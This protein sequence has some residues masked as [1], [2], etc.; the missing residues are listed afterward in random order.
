MKLS[1]LKQHT[2]IIKTGLFPANIITSNQLIHL[3]SKHDLLLDSQKLFDEMPQRNVFTWN[4]IIYAYIHS[5][6]MSQARFL[7]DSAPFKDSVTY[8]S[9]ISGYANTPGF[10]KQAVELFC[11]MQQTEIPFDDFTLTTML[12]LTAKL[13]ALL[14]GMQL[15]SYMLK[16]AY[17]FNSFTV[18]SLIDMYSKCGCFCD[19]LKVFEGSDGVMDLVSKNAMV[20]ACCRQGEM[21]RAFELFSRF[22]ELNDTVS[23]N[24]IIAGYAQ[25]G[26]FSKAFESFIQM[27]KN[28]IRWNEHTFTSMLSACSSMRSEKHGR[29]VHAWVIKKRWSLN[30]YISGSLVDMYCKCGNVAYAEV[31]NA[32]T[33]TENAFSITSLIVGHSS[34]G[35]MAEARKLFDSLSEKNLVAWTALFSGYVRSRHCEAVFE[36][37]LH[38]SKTEGQ[39]PDASMLLSVL[40]ACA[41]QAALHPG[42][43]I[44]TYIL[45][46][47]IEMEDKLSTSFTDMYAKCGHIKYA[48]NIFC[49]VLNRDRIM[50]NTMIAGYAHNGYENEAI[51]LFEKMLESRIKPDAI[52]FIAILSACRHAG[53]VDVG[54]KYF[55]SMKE[56]YG[57]VPE[58]DHYSCMVDLYGRT[59]C[60]DKATNGS[61]KLVR[62][63]EE[64]LLT[65]EADNGARYVQLANVYAAEGNWSEMCRIRGKM[66][67][68]DV[69]KIAGCSWLYIENRIITFTSGDRSHSQAEA[70]YS[71]LSSLYAEILKTKEKAPT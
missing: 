46:M 33:R 17:D 71:M 23:W 39:P 6:H 45:R 13:S 55:V 8:N 67:V 15:H 41:I 57:I 44:H 54:E 38:F 50:Y 42:K 62:E 3:Y 25:N 5:H 64:K 22:S 14:Y 49:R 59:N 11:V 20:A 51:R 52:T 36:L 18:S 56:D 69:K 43:Q 2:H 19:A 28:G 9:I 16:T 12:N 34:K 7:F 37:L 10:E 30:S 68:G 32:S 21:E 26:D 1:S 35:N 58:I 60:L 65:I 48:E 61:A 66:G 27:G 63:A 24:T 4:A 40:G 29:E 70:I 31:V 47:G 53:L